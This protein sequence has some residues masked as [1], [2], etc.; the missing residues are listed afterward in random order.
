MTDN[1]AD[2]IVRL[3]REIRDN[4]WRSAPVYPIYYPVRPNYSQ[5]RPY[6]APLFWGN[7]TNTTGQITSSM[8]NG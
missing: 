5:Y 3:L 1:Q 8:F 4:Q 2:E 6:Q 7:N